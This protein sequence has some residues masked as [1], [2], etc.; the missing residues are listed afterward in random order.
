M[1][2]TAFFELLS[3]IAAFLATIFIFDQQLHRP[4][5]YKLLWTLG[6]LFYGIAAL[7]AFAGAARYWTVLDYKLWY[8]FGGVLTAA[9]LGLGSFW[10]LWNKTAARVLTAIATVI[11]VVA[12]VVVIVAPVSAATAAAMARMDSVQVTDVKHFPVLPGFLT[13]LTL[14][15]NIP[16]ALFLFGGAVWSAWTFLR[17][18]APGYRVVSMVLLALG[19]VF[20]SFTTGFQ[21]LGFSGTAALGEFL[22]A[23]C[24]LVGLM[25]SLDVFTVFRVPFTAI[26][27]HERA[28]RAPKVH[29][30]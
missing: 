17:R 3:A 13:I 18:S 29:A 14:L 2:A 23:I 15:M 5:P 10:L 26:V 28:E 7:A 8:Y 21:R 12:A 6:L 19:S 30:G 11:A 4:R 27:L 16:G 22:G 24:L 20:P 1:S 9:F 25:I